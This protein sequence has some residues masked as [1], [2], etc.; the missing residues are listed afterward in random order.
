MSSTRTLSQLLQIQGIANMA[1]IR[2]GGE[3][4]SPSHVLVYQ[5]SPF[6]P[7]IHVMQAMTDLFFTPKHQIINNSYLIST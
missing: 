3:L 6:P 4:V 2:K 5:Y 1:G 7:Q